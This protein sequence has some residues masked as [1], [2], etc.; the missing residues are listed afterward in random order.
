MNEVNAERRE[1]NVPQVIVVN[2]LRKQVF[3]AETVIV[4]DVLSRD[5]NN[6]EVMFIHVLFLEKQLILK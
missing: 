4:V 2:V 6:A 1:S 5:C 3:Q